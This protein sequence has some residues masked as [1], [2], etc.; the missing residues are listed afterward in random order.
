MSFPLLL[1]VLS[2]FL[3]LQRSCSRSCD[4]SSLVFHSPALIPTLLVWTSFASTLFTSVVLHKLLNSWRASVLHLWWESCL[5]CLRAILPLIHCLATLSFFSDHW[6]IVD[7]SST[8]WRQFKANLTSNYVFGRYK[9]KSPCLAYPIDEETWLEFVKTRTDPKWQEIRKKAKFIVAKND[10]PHR[11]SRGGYDLL[12][13]RIVEEK[14]KRRQVK[15]PSAEH[16]CPPSPPGDLW[17]LARTT[18]GGNM[19]SEHTLQVSQRIAELKQ[20]RS[21]GNF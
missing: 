4:S 20:Q 14:L 8:K 17:V 3:V 18:F 19:T 21:Q 5:S 6:S 7:D 10:T 11:L 12:E 1:S 2:F 15:S 16:M 9:D 13:R